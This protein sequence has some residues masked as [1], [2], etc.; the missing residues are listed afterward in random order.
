MSSEQNDVRANLSFSVEVDRTIE[1]VRWLVSL[2]GTRLVK[3]VEGWNQTFDPEQDNDEMLAAMN[4]VKLKLLDVS[5]MIEQYQNMVFGFLDQS[6][7]EP[8]PETSAPDI[9]VDQLKQKLQELE[10]FNGF[11]DKINDQE[12]EEE[13]GSGETSV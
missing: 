8:E 7:K 1:L 10:M 13:D 11:L 5:R 2:E 3:I 6:N 4:K 9:T 12:E